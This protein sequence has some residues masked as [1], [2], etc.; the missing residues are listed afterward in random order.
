MLETIQQSISELT[1]CLEF[2]QKEI[3]KLKMEKEYFKGTICNIWN[4]VETI[5]WEIRKQKESLLGV[6]S[7]GMRDN[8]LFSGISETD[9]VKQEY[10]VKEFMTKK[11][12][13]LPDLVEK[14]TFFK[15]HRMGNCFRGRSRTII[16]RF[17]HFKIRG[18]E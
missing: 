9:N 3:D 4:G 8:L 11:M 15:V 6:Q 16:V 17:E 1:A 12:K 18:R 7:W 13:L 2:S 10:S 5:Y 14:I